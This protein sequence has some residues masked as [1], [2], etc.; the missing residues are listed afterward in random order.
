MSELLDDLPTAHLEYGLR[1][2]TVGDWLVLGPLVAPLSDPKIAQNDAAR[3][4]ALRGMP[5]D[6]DEIAQLP[7]ER[8][9]S[10]VTVAEGVTQEAMWRVVNTLD[11]GWVD[12]AQRVEMPAM[13]CAWVY[14]QVVLQQDA[15]E[16]LLTTASPV[17]LW[18]NGEAVFGY[19]ELPDAPVVLRVA[20]AL[21]EGVNEI[22]VCVANVGAGAVP[23]ML[24]AEIV[25][26]AG[27]V[28][29]PTLLE[30]VARRQKLATVM[31]HAYLAQDVYSR[32]QRVVLRWPT[33]MNL[34]D[35]LT[36][37]LQ[38]PAGRIYG[39]ANPMI[40]RGA[41]VDFGEASQFP[42]GQYE[43]VLQPQFEE[44][45]VQQM[46]VQRRIPLQ[47]RNGKWSSVY[48][49]SLDE[50]RQE[51]LVDAAKRSG[52]LYAEIAKG[53][54]GKWGDLRH[55]VLEQALVALSES[56]ATSERTLLALLSW[57]ARSGDLPD[58]PAEMAWALEE[59]VP[60][61]LQELHRDSG[62]VLATC[63][64]LAGQLY[65]HRGFGSAHFGDWHQQ[66]AE[67]WI[68][69]WLRT[70]SQ[71]G[72]PGGESQ[73]AYADALTALSTL[74]D[75][76]QS[77]EI[78]ELAAVVLDKLAYLI[79][80]QSFLGAWGGSQDARDPWLPSARLGPLSGVM[81]LWWG[82]GA[83]HADCAATVALACA[84]NY[85][86]PEIIAAVGLDRQQDNELRRRDLHAVR[87]V[88]SAVN[89]RAYRTGDYLLA[90][91]P[92]DWAA[93]EGSVLWQVTLGPDAVISGNRPANS[94][95][96]E[97]WR[98]NYWRGNACPVRVAQ[99]QDW[100][101]V[102]YGPSEQGRLPYSH[103]YFPQ[104][105][106]DEVRVEAGWVMA[107]KGNGYVALTATGGVEVVVAGPT[108]RREVRAAGESV[109][110]AQMG[111]AASDGTFADFGQKVLAQPLS[112]ASDGVTMTTLRGQLITF[113]ANKRLDDALLVDGEP[114]RL[115]EFPHLESIYGGAAT[116]PA[117]SV[118]IYYQEHRMRLDFGMPETPQAG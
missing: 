65:P 81:R 42:D 54:L 45:Y 102:A 111:R 67:A 43:I 115:Q 18:I 97:A 110:I 13:L 28:T 100:L 118:E 70:V 66:H 46:R 34:I 89:R 15:T 55:E 112:L 88:E 52:S 23:M 90:S 69:A 5:A 64:L 95:L 68:G 40:Q 84:E 25:G 8:A 27:S 77:D 104:A 114:Q 9:T 32:E 74:V 93:G 35:A 21:Q 101:A 62:I 29:L 44:Y 51:A 41:K 78:A 47:I 106:F 48:Y 108:A 33:D 87:G 57:V 2:G 1:N 4:H 16:V 30:P 60:L 109:W 19:N 3:R 116:L 38:S 11:D 103:A 22:L 58:F 72:L 99:W 98:Q 56:T 91:A 117:E 82:Q 113:R 59:R 17:Q 79:A 96:Y 92:G 6:A 76:A 10:V 14:A 80:L 63:H 71:Q 107:R 85:A 36:A 7:T 105:A 37:R 26:G 50:R 53:A 31:G 75:L 86:L 49:G 94:S 73:N 61:A 12:L 83:F 20:A 39:E 24:A